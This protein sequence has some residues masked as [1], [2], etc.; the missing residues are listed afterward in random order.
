VLTPA[1]LLAFSVVAC[2]RRVQLA[3]EAVVLDMG[4]YSLPGAAVKPGTDGQA[5]LPDLPAPTTTAAAAATG[6]ADSTSPEKGTTAAQ[7]GGKAAAAGAGA[8]LGANRAGAAVTGCVRLYQVLAP[9]C[10]ARALL[11]GNSLALKR[12]A[13]CHDLPYFSAPGAASR[14]LLD[15]LLVEGP[16]GGGGGKVRPN[17]NWGGGGGGSRVWLRHKYR[18][19]VASSSAA[20]AAARVLSVQQEQHG[21]G[22]SALP[23]FQSPFSSGQL[24][25]PALASAGGGGKQQQVPLSLSP[26][27]R[28]HLASLY[29]TTSKQPMLSSPILE[30]RQQLDTS[31]LPP[32]SSGA[33]GAASA[34]AAAAASGAASHA[35]GGS[36]SAHGSLQ[37]TGTSASAWPVVSIPLRG[38]TTL[39]SGGGG[40]VGGP[41]SDASTAAG[42]P[43]ASVS[44]ITFVFASATLPRSATAAKLLD[45][46]H[47]AAAFAATVSAVVRQTLMAFA[48]AAAASA[49]AADSSSSGGGG[50]G[51]AGYLFRE[52]TADMKY[53]LAFRSPKVSCRE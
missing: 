9:K 23:L 40:G 22:S 51:V 38:L 15:M 35:E 8:Q 30:Q 43:C 37:S 12:G 34:A 2:R 24:L 45:G 18:L 16:R 4:L 25:L 42:G 39:W 11:F 29:G 48:A 26:M 7:Q 47:A 13:R 33:N 53:I 52:S 10:V 46:G 32:T 5:L 1:L 50:G 3:A 36:D 44:G 21:S 19:P 17:A 49:G 20:A 27:G 41:C 6:D 31:L 28:A 14:S